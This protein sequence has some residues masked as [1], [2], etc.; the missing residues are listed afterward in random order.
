MKVYHKMYV[1]VR[2]VAMIAGWHQTATT[3]M[4]KVCRNNLYL[5]I[6]QGDFPFLW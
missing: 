4:M 1:K 6:L 2:V 5:H 3:A